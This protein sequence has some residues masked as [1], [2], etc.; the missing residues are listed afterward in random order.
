[1]DHLR[2]KI[3]SKVVL[4][5]EL[6][7]NPQD[8]EAAFAAAKLSRRPR[9]LC[10]QLMP[11]LYIA[12]RTYH[13]LARMPGT[14]HQH[15]PDCD[16]YETLMT[17]SG[18]SGY[19]G[20]FKEE[21]GITDVKFAFTL[22]RM[23]T[24]K[25]NNTRNPEPSHKPVTKRG[26]SGL[27]GLM[28]YLWEKS[29]NNIWFPVKK[30]QPVKNRTWR[31]I[32]WHLNHTVSQVKRANVPL[33]ELL[34]VVPA[35]DKETIVENE[36]AWA[37]Y[38]TPVLE[39][40]SK[41]AIDANEPQL[42]R[43]VLGEVG[44]INTTEYGY[45]LS[46]KQTTRK[47]FFAKDLHAKLLRSYPGAMALQFD[48]T[49][50]VICL[51]LVTATEKG[52]LVLVDAALMR[53]TSHYLPVDSSYEVTVANKLVEEGRRF[54]KPLRYEA[55]ELTLPDF[56]LL[57]TDPLRLPMEIYGMTGRD[58]YDAR[59]AEKRR[60]YR[61]TVADSWEWEPSVQAD[62]APFPPRRQKPVVAT[63]E[64]T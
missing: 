30:G 41:A 32:A 26:A 38:I 36:L 52:N 44:G 43:M 59:K 13:Y 22:S 24:A 28:H 54:E 10:N 25:Q 49:E 3:G 14:G 57:D 1:M 62:M 60:H 46:L 6:K 37:R 39:S 42:F 56:I 9:C 16:F 35:F 4:Y 33:Q 12:K 48:G 29:K 15:D 2:I 63:E 50:R 55:S 45:S 20:A 53:C 47:L 40:A 18:K 31:S 21:D 7:N 17:D 23:R 19:E 51:A 11:E 34:Y 58:D 61:E 27:L 64:I 8:H 5:R